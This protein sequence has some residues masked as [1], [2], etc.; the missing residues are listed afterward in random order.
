MQ[1]YLSLKM[2]NIAF[3]YGKPMDFDFSPQTLGDRIV[4]VKARLDKSSNELARE[5]GV[6]PAQMN[7]Y[8]RNLAVPTLIVAEKIA[9]CGGVNLE[10]LA[11]G[12]GEVLRPVDSDA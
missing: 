12:K 9:R 1:D 3:I 10:W 2:V 8:I 11:T 5:V 7:R 6:S 4:F